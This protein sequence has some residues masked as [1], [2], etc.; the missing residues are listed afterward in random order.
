VTVLD[1][2]AIDL[3]FGSGG[4]DWFFADMDGLENDDDLLLDAQLREEIDLL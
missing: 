3:L 1:D 4:R 2:Q